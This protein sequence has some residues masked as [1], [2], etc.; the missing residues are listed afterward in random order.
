M[1]CNDDNDSNIN[2]TYSD[3]NNNG[4]GSDDG[5]DNESSDDDNVDLC[6]FKDL[7]IESTLPG[8]FVH[9]YA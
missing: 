8:Q 5:D 2:G 3:V 9:L 7:D 4:K 6:T 1:V